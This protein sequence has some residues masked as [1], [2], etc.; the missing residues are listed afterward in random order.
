VTQTRRRGY[1]KEKRILDWRASVP[2]L[3]AGF[4][5]SQE[6]V[7]RNETPNTDDGAR[8]LDG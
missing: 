6:V 4:S 2:A 3:P 8:L 1:N 7:L 5:V